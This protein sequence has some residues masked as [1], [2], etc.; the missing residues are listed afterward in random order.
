METKVCNKCGKEKSLDEFY[1]HPYTRDRKLHRCKGCI[2]IEKKERWA[3]GSAKESYV[4]QRYGISLEEY[5]ELMDGAIC[6]ICDKP[7]TCLDHCH[8]SGRIRQP[9][10]GQCNSGLGMFGE[11]PERLQR[12]ID[13]V[14]EYA[15]VQ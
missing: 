7:A 2:S 8:T 4:R 6:P 15:L 10:C 14:E 3:E 11:D 9:L 5:R 13:Y 1:D 12:A